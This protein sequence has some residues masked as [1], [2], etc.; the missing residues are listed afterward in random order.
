MWLTSN[1]PIV[2]ESIDCIRDGTWRDLQPPPDFAQRQ[3]SL[4]AEM[5]KHQYLVSGKRQSKW[6]QDVIELPKK[7][8]LHA[9]DGGH[10]GH[11]V[12]GPG[13]AVGHPLPTCL[14]DEIEGKRRPGH[15]RTIVPAVPGAEGC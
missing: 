5:Q 9:H 12:G 10:H 1:Q 8:L 3:F 2:L 6:T 14:R 13:P 15:A 7:E 4:T 11:A